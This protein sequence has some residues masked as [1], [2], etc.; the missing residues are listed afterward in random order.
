MINEAI[1]ALIPMCAPDVAPNT[2]AQIIRVES[3]GNPLAINVNGLGKRI[4]AKTQAEAAEITRKYIKEGYTVDVGL[5]QVNSS[6]FAALGY[7]DRIEELFEACNNIAAGS[8][9]LKGFYRQSSQS[10]ADEQSALRGAISA[11]NTGSF[12][13]GIKNGYVTKVYAEAPIQLPNDTQND[14]LRQALQAP[15]AINIDVLKPTHLT[16]ATK[17]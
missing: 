7:A 14:L 17:E 4:N 9:V 16:L 12:Q 6:N 13:K 8:K 15:T 3:K 10:F 5:M 11:Y 1:L 2:I